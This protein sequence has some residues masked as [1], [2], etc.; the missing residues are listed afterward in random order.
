MS[1]GCDVV[2]SCLKFN[3]RIFGSL[4]GKKYVLTVVLGRIIRMVA[5]CICFHEKNGLN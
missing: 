5:G 1:F 3:A 2:S 4:R